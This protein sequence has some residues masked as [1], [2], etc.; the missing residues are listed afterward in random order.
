MI[1]QVPGFEGRIGVAIFSP[2]LHRCVAQKVIPVIPLSDR[3]ASTA[4]IPWTPGN[5]MEDVES[6][7]FKV[8]TAKAV[9]VQ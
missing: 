6:A 9:Q 5:Y 4:L 2:D 7:D 1:A 8:D 3:I